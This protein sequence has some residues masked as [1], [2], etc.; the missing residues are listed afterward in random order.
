MGQYHIWLYQ[1]L[2]SLRT[3][4]ISNKSNA[5]NLSKA[6]PRA[7]GA[8]QHGYHPA[9]DRNAVVCIGGHGVQQAV[10]TYKSWT[11]GAIRNSAF[12]QSPRQ[13]L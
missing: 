8:A 10:G 4:S 6:P 5:V 12:G 7:G 9:K 3:A 11:L 13:E 1:R 2:T